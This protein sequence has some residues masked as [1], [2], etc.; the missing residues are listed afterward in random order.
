MRTLLAGIGGRRT[1]LSTR[2]YPAGH[3]GADRHG[4]PA[5]PSRI[6]THPPHLVDWDDDESTTG[7]TNPLVGNGARHDQ[8]LTSLVT[9]RIAKDGGP[10]CRSLIARGPGDPLL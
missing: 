6:A 7:T 9:H 8:V 10:C 3:P 4:Q 1:I 2:K 5:I